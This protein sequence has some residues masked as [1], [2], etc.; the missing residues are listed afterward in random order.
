M[1]L[2][3]NE[4]LDLRTLSFIKSILQPKLIVSAEGITSALWVN[5]RVINCLCQLQFLNKVQIMCIFY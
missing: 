4:M 3:G 2:T 1:I 5:P